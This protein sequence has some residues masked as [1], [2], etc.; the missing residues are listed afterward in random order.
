M[1]PAFFIAGP[2][3]AQGRKLGLID[4]RQIA[5]SVAWLLGVELRAANQAPFDLAEKG[6]RRSEVAP[7]L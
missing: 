7:T 4:M 3:I 6:G 2:G 1:R 5:P